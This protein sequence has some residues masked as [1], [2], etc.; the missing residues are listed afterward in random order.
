MNG[1]Y[2]IENVSLAGSKRDVIVI[3][4]RY[5]YRK[6]KSSYDVPKKPQM[7]NEPNI[8]IAFSERLKPN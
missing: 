3:S 4:E 7:E 1:S 5:F 8:Q 6:P 2:Q